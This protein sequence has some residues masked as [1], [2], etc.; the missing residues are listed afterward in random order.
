M[1][2]RGPQDGP[3]MAPRWSGAAESRALLEGPKRPALFCSQRQ[4]D[5]T[6]RRMGG[7]SEAFPFPPRNPS[8]SP[9]APGS[10]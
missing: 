6:C 10:K 4:T 3:K 2:P 1:A 9:S 5:S 7:V 8:S